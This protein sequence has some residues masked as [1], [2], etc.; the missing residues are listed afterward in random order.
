[1]RSPRPLLIALVLA[2]LLAWSTPAG[3]VAGFGDV[4]GDRYFTA[5]VQ[6]MVAEGITNGTSDTCFSPDLPVTR[7]MAAAFLWRMNG[8][9][10]ATPHPF[11][12]VMKDWQQSPVSWLFA[13][14]ITVGTSDTTF[15][16]EDTLTRGE[17]AALLWRM[18][19]EPNATPHPFDDVMKDW[20]Q[21]PV[22]W[23]FAEGITVGTSNTTFSPNQPVTRAQVA[24]FL[25]RA[26]GSPV[27]AIDPASPACGVP[28]P[29]DGFDS[30]FIGHS[31]FKPMAQE[32]EALAL[33]AGFA[34]HTQTVVFSGGATGAPQGLWIQDGKRSEIQAVLDT[35]NVELF[36]MTYHP[37]HPTL[38]GY[39]N[40]LNYALVDNPNVIVFIAVPWAPNPVDVSAAT[41]DAGYTAAYPG[42]GSA[43][44]DPLRAEYP[45][46][47][48]FAIPYGFA[49]V[50]LYNRWDD[51]TLTDV[52]ELVG[53]HGSGVFRDDFGHADLILE[54]L[55]S[56]VWLQAIYG[57][58]L[59]TF[60]AGYPWAIDLNSIAAEILAAHDPEYDAP[61]R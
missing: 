57:V 48:F 37:N 34:G 2:G 6:W 12:D 53:S 19:G 50:E 30:L 44:I 29:G 31:F 15:S 41:Y 38:E 47:T 25:H 27:I 10:N 20:Q 52:S 49:A 1:M 22:S 5:P 9:P 59:A 23:L 4:D 26:E 39:R 46:T 56:L 43:V 3:G 60:D 54:D 51:G 17:V 55:A 58:D 42:I 40:W 36:G 21:S 28:N 8:E 32:M 24:T 61:W 11:D 7:G 18:N 16:P 13:E 35:G 33:P 14:G 45:D